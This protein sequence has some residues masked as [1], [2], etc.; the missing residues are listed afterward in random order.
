MSFLQDIVAKLKI[1][2]LQSKAHSVVGI[3]IGSS[4]IKV[5]EIKKE[6]GKIVLA[7]YG[8]VAL[9]PYQDKPVGFAGPLDPD[10]VSNAVLAVLKESH[11]ESRSVVIT[12]QSSASLLFVLRLPASAEKSLAEVVPNEARKYIPVPISEVTLNWILIPSHVE[13]SLNSENEAPLKNLKEHAPD[14]EVL[15]IAI[16]N[17][18]L[19]TYKNISAQTSL[20]PLHYEIE[21]FS[22][23]RAVLHHELV[24]VGIIDCGATQTRI[25]LV[26]YGMV[27]KYHT[28]NRGGMLITE[29]IMRSLGQSFERAEELKRTVGLTDEKHQDVVNA[30]H[31][32]V[33]GLVSEIKG[34]M[35]DFEKQYNKALDR[36]IL[37]GGGALMPGLPELLSRELGLPVVVGDPFNKTSYPE[38]LN[39]VLSHTGPIFTGAVGAALYALE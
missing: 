26:H 32:H 8:E 17:D 24:P 6:H 31:T 3:D 1:P 15:V 30:I 10:M 39:T 37:V 19:A 28:I 23:I 13:E 18:A 12:I 36:I 33:M 38:F 4:S 14:I 20:Q 16:R 34:S 21:I 2:V 27:M 9:G 25:A 35:L 7:T 5:V 22:M 11:V 29:N